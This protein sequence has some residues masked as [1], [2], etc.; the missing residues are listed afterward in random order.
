MALP[1][2]TEAPVTTETLLGR[3]EEIKPIIEKHRDEAEENGRLSGPVAE[4]LKEAGF[5]RLYVARSYGGLE[6]D[7]I[8]FFRVTERISRLDA[9][10]GW[11]IA[12]GN[13][14]AY[15][16]SHLSEAGTDAIFGSDPN[17]T[18]CG[19]L[20]SMGKAIAE[21]GGY[22]FSSQAPFNTGC[23]FADWC[24]MQGQVHRDDAPSDAEPEMIAL[25]CPMKD[26]EIIDNW[27]VIGMRATASNDV[28]VK[29]ALVPESLTFPLETL[30][31]PRKNP[32][33]QGDLYRMPV[34][35]NVPIHLLPVLGALRAALDWVSD[36]AQ[37]KTPIF[38]S[39]KL[40]HRSIAQINYAKALGRY[41]ASYALLEASLRSVWEKVRAGQAVTSE[42]KAEF[43]LS[44]A[45][46]N[47]MIADGIRLAASV[48]G[49]S[50]IR[51]GNPLERA[52]RDIEVLHQHAYMNESRFGTVA[53]VLWGLEPDFGFISI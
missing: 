40:R 36:L 29:D 41:R 35:H 11:L 51:K 31:K 20:N 3:L 32:H 28:R 33:F 27:D 4:A 5:L 18:V 47:E 49:T 34:S 15:I 52:M 9:S 38:T 2:A 23:S 44:G 17:A 39:S 10:V 25:F 26:A 8:T 21:N 42:D 12:N 43:F 13:A 14:L 16:T 48:A 53:Q 50:W 22:R 1:A 46:A 30:G 24:M 45:Q 19:S 7:P 6:I 37:N